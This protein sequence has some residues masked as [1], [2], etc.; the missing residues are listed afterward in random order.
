[1]GWNYGMMS[2]WFGTFNVFGSFV[3]LVVFVDLVLLGVWLWKQI[4]KK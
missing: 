1:M 3:S 4:Q 2:G